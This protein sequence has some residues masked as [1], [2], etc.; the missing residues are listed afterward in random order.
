MIHVTFVFQSSRISFSY[1]K[2]TVAMLVSDDNSDP[3]A[4]AFYINPLPAART[5]WA[6]RLIV[7]GYLCFVSAP[8][9]LSH[10]G[11]MGGFAFLD[12]SSVVCAQGS[13][14]LPVLWISVETAPSRTP[15]VPKLCAHLW[16][17]WAHRHLRSACY[18]ICG[19]FVFLKLFVILLGFFFFK[20][21]GGVKNEF[22]AWRVVFLFF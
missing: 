11:V 17:L 5:N 12:G 3:N 22:F 2:K 10:Q 8:L 16:H 4:V 7:F 14:L 9:P 13:R 6:A 19:W 21:G 18:C 20:G 1:W 15:F